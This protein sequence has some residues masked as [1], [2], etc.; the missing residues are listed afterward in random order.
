MTE[1]ADTD[2][3]RDGARGADGDEGVRAAHAA[4]ATGP[5]GDAAA[6]AAPRGAAWPTADADAW[7]GWADELLGLAQVSSLLD[8]GRAATSAIALPTPAVGDL[9]DALAAG[10]L[11]RVMGRP[12]EW[13]GRPDVT[14]P[15]A[16]AAAVSAS[17]DV[18]RAERLA[19]DGDADL[20]GAELAAGRL[21]SA[22]DEGEV[23]QRLADMRRVA[24]TTLGE[25]GDR[26][27]FMAFGALGWRRDEGDDMR[28]APVV[29]W[30]VDLVRRGASAGYE[31][32]ARPE[33]PTVNAALVETLR[34]QAGVTVRGVDPLP[35]DA[36]GVDL[37]MA[38]DAFRVRI[39][40]TGEG[41]LRDWRL[42]EVAVLGLFPETLSTL[43]RDVAAGA[44][45]AARGVVVAPPDAVETPAG[46][47]AAAGSDAPAAA[48]PGDAAT[49]RADAPA[50]ADMHVPAGD[51]PSAAP[52][53][54]E[55]PADALEPIELDG[56]QRRAVACAARGANVAVVGAPG[57]GKSQ[58]A[59]AVVAAALGQGKR[60]LFVSGSAA[61]GDA[62]LRRLAAVGVDRACLDLRAP[63]AS[64]ADACDQLERAL[65]TTRE[66]GAQGEHLLA[67][68][69]A[70]G[71]AAELDRHARAL[72]AR[73]AAGLT[74]R[75]QIC[76]YEAYR[77]APDAVR[78]RDADLAGVTG[79]A[80]LETRFRHVER[81][82]AAARAVGDPSSHP[83]RRIR[84]TAVARDAAGDL[85]ARLDALRAAAEDMT[86]AARQLHEVTGLPEPVTDDDWRDAARELELLDAWRVLPASWRAL[87][88][89][90][91]FLQALGYLIGE[92]D[93]YERQAAEANAQWIPAFFDEIGAAAV[94]AD[95]QA[96]RTQ[97]VFGR[98]RAMQRL[99]DKLAS[100]SIV[101]FHEE[102]VPRAIA[103][104]RQRAGAR[105]QLQ[106]DLRALAPMLA[107][108][109]EG[110][111]L[112]WRAVRKVHAYA[113]DLHARTR[114]ELDRMGV[115]PA[116]FAACRATDVSD[117]TT[118]TTL[119]GA[120]A[121]RRAYESAHAAL[122]A[123]VGEVA[124][125][126]GETQA[127]ADLALCADAPR[128]LGEL[129]DWLAW[130]GLVEEGREL[131]LEPV[132][133]ALSTGLDPALA[134][135]A[136]KRGLYRAMC[137]A[138]LAADDVASRFSGAV[139]DE[140]VRQFAAV[141]E[142]LRELSARELRARLA[143]QVADALALAR[144]DPQMA[145]IRRA[146]LS[147]GKGMVLRDFLVQVGDVAARLC[148]CVLANPDA[149][150]RHL[151]VSADRYD[152]VVFDEASRLRTAE[153][154]GALAR[155]A[156]VVVIG[157][158]NQLPPH[159]GRAPSLL[160]DALAAGVPT[161]C[162]RTHYR[163]AHADLIAFASRAFY[164][165]TLRALPSADAAAHVT[166]QTVSTAAAGAGDA[167]EAREAEARAIV[168]E[169]RRR[170]N[171]DRA[172]QAGGARVA[173]GAAPDAPAPAAPGQVAA[174]DDE[175]SGQS[176]EVILFDDAER[177]LV[178]RLLETAFT[179]DARF[180]RWATLGA[181]PLV[182]RDAW[183]AQGDERDV[184]LVA[185]GRAT[186]DA[187]RHG[188]APAA[189]ADD[190]AWRLVNVAATRARREMMVFTTVAPERIGAAR[191][192]SEGELALRAL[193][194]YARDGS[195]RAVPAACRAW[196]RLLGAPAAGGEAPDATGDAPE[197]AIA[198]TIADELA[199]C[200]YR[201]RRDVGAAGVRVDVAVED[202]V[203]PTSLVAGVLL[204]GASYDADAPA[205]DRELA[206]PRGLE[207]LGWRVRRVWALDW[208]ASPDAVLDA[209]CDWLD[210]VFGHQRDPRPRRAG[211][212]IVP[213]LP[214]LPITDAASV[215]RAAAA[216]GRERW[217]A[218][219]PTSL[220]GIS[221]YDD[222]AEAD[223]RPLGA[224]SPATT[225][226][227]PILADSDASPMAVLQSVPDPTQPHVAAPPAPAEGGAAS[228]APVAAA[229]VG[230]AAGGADAPDRA[231]APDQRAADEPRARA[232]VVEATDGA[233]AGAAG[234]G[235]RAAV[236]QAPAR[237]GA[238]AAPE[239]FTFYDEL[240]DGAVIA[241]PAAARATTPPH[242]TMREMPST[243]A[244]VRAALTTD[245][246]RPDAAAP[247]G[248][249][250][251]PVAPADAPGAEVPAD[252][253]AGADASP[254]SPGA[255]ARPGDS[256]PGG[257]ATPAAPRDRG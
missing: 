129:R 234:P 156:G 78:L 123:L 218:A 124:R 44:F 65:A 53:D 115:D 253:V 21:R 166:L 145:V 86:R 178:S 88:D 164:A 185:V 127:D 31:L 97:G 244:F 24:D 87:P 174:A 74:L 16:D 8:V 79:A 35:R 125:D 69:E 133:I 95:W 56:A 216:V 162:L 227:I 99:V 28:Y 6:D 14:G 257:P 94:E 221:D 144:H 165:G 217:G 102:D 9:E 84:G 192:A 96:A 154:A 101:D 25:R 32:I 248:I 188:A 171:A 170:C 120:L 122:V 224:A 4:G 43:L 149:V 228:A 252:A 137:L 117:A 193:V 153:A 12:N 135:A 143:G 254:T 104:L 64:V 39:A 210:G 182:V 75:E 118:A 17:R 157:D 175:G 63:R 249:A 48:G 119:R 176:Y 83:L 89:P 112:D 163:S 22:L 37:R 237:P 151:A 161:V 71:L 167:A 134:L 40:A 54:V 168:G 158:P 109:G 232:E 231:G 225:A 148:P 38:F 18:E 15:L 160:D 142:R 41:R 26:T 10:T 51:A 58:V 204:D 222:L 236:P 27:L 52:A 82:A 208:W 30:P 215:E 57:T 11:L 141:D 199:A 132:A 108:Y 206:V 55:T 150:A 136:Y 45:R 173:G 242:S 93:Q 197:D 245:D 2:A 92:H 70:A 220:A 246:A 229:A 107:G 62:L 146:S 20:L 72:R 152:V 159:G 240:I 169:L 46:A 214:R 138:S 247:A 226:R 114:D 19:A 207:R 255:A 110:A 80:A 172:R 128:H 121:R 194:T 36:N 201:V 211:H 203:D 29:L 113:S 42:A 181:E 61:A 213:A 177:A 106:D 91:G 230:R 223:E 130:R 184:V 68:E 198:A 251:A 179:T 98:R 205:R 238:P 147:R 34:R 49:G 126:P 195:A 50:D 241:P 187:A 180:R 90:G 59:A 209:L 200:G 5:A 7:R 212:G 66:D 60:V 202:P 155:A 3:R 1:G 183:D 191:G 233:A 81:L 77:T 33:G 73:N 189:L 105:R 76:R 116:A 196:E 235:P 67:R 103:A 139:F 186:G 47:P 23:R 250:T 243:P 131:G 85:P 140:A 190:D 256:S 219:E 239:Q 111:R 100:Y 13:E